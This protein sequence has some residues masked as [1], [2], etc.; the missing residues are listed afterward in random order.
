MVGGACT[1]VAPVGNANGL[2]DENDHLAEEDEKEE[3]EADGAVG[4]ETGDQ[5]IQSEGSHLTLLTVLVLHSHLKA[6]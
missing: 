6:L 1:P 5:E 2:D 3:E 4:P